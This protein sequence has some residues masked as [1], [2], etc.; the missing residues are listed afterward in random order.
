MHVDENYIFISLLFNASNIFI[1]FDKKKVIE[2][3][4]SKK[5]KKEKA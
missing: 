3:I 4:E 5:R 2:S 1:I